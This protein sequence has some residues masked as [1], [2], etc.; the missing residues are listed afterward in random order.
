[1]SQRNVEQVIGRLV[2]DEGF[3]RRF[4][5][6]PSAAIQELIESGL[7]FNVCEVRALIAL[8]RER[9]ARFAEAIHPSIQKVELR[10]PDAEPEAKVE[11]DVESEPR[12]STKERKGDEDAAAAAVAQA[13]TVGDCP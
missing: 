2:T 4:A 12:R 11:S 5:A 1:M 9:V 10:A 6:D 8:D 13:D 7:H 3:R